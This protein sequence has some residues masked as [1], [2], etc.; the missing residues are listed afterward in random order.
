MS[1]GTCGHTREL[2]SPNCASRRNRKCKGQG[3]LLAVRLP[4]WKLVRL[5]VQLVLLLLRVVLLLLPLKSLLQ[6]PASPW[7]RPL[8]VLALLTQLRLSLLVRLL[9]LP[10]PLPQL[11][12][13]AVA[14]SIA[15][16]RRLIRSSK[17]LAVHPASV[18][19]LLLTL[20]LLLLMP[21]PLLLM[22][23]TLVLLLLTLVLLLLA[24]LLLLLLLL[25]LLLPLLLALVLLLLAPL[26]LL[27]APLLL[28]LLALAQELLLLTSL[29]RACHPRYLHT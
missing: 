8:A 5:L 1:G 24:P 18:L 6:P 7:V 27:L 14:P 9:A 25:P 10:R 17:T 29:I 22:P 3:L 26:L 15:P 2:P 16:D 28:L 11:P 4:L 21:A 12:S 13:R 20:V 23:L 19:L